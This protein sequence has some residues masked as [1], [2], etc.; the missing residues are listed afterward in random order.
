MND[1]TLHVYLDS[2]G[3]WCKSSFQNAGPTNFSFSN[4]VRKS[5]RRTFHPDREKS[6]ALAGVALTFAACARARFITSLLSSFVWVH[7]GLDFSMCIC[8]LFGPVSHLE[9]DFLSHLFSLIFIGQAFHT[10]LLLL[11]S[12]LVFCS[13]RL[14]AQ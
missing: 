6:L 14:C 12:A 9:I 5:L 2:S 1:F 10:S 7:L 11:F 13:V 3:G 4:Y 8:V